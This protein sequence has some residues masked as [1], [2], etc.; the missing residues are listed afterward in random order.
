MMG[1]HI[2]FFPAGCYLSKSK[3]T[4]NPP[5]TESPLRS[6]SIDVRT[7]SPLHELPANILNIHE[8]LSRRQPCAGDDLGASAT[9]IVTCRHR[10]D[11]RDCGKPC[12]VRSQRAGGMFCQ[13]LVD[14]ADHRFCHCIGRAYPCFRRLSSE[15]DDHSL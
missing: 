4:E 14:G 12:V 1:F 6:R 10:I 5:N 9:A 3:I 8:L 7:K 15:S 13:A 2:R 11:L